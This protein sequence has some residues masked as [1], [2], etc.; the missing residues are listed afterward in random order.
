MR[1]RG[2]SDDII[3]KKRKQVRSHKRAKD[4]K[5]AC[6]DPQE[7]SF[8]VPRQVQGQDQPPALVEGDEATADAPLPAPTITHTVASY[9]Y[10]NY[11]IRLKYP[12]MP[13]I[14]TGR[15]KMRDGFVDEWFPIEF[16]SQEFGKT[17]DADNQKLTAALQYNDERP[18]RESVDRIR[19]MVRIANDLEKNGLTHSDFLSRFGM[20]IDVEPQSFNGKVESEPKLH[21]SEANPAQVNN[22]DWR[23]ADQRRIAQVFARPARFH[24]FSS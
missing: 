21:F 16:L 11:G 9:F 19:E 7:H 6:N 13:L 15:V 22:G 12:N 18:G 2:K 24:S 10:E 1:A 20:K 5:W 4:I 23:L 3:E 8:T 17:R 14:K